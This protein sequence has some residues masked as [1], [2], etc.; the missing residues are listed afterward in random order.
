[1]K[2][3]AIVNE[4][5]GLILDSFTNEQLAFQVMFDYQKTGIHCYLETIE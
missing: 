1:M 5:T 2:E 4:L 3:Y